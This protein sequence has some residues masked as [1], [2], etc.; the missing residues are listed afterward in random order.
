[1]FNH[2]L[3]GWVA[4]CGK[5]ASQVKMSKI[6]SRES[7]NK[8]FS[9][10]YDFASPLNHHSWCTYLLDPSNSSFRYRITI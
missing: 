2:I 5:I 7:L 9:E 4:G 8:L 1:M 3:K 6:T 10:V